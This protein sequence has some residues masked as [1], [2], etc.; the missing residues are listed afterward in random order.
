MG[1]Y[2]VVI[3]ENIDYSIL[4]QDYPFA[5]DRIEGYVELM[6][7][8]C[9]SGKVCFFTEYLSSSSYTILTK[10]PRNFNTFEQD[11]SWKT[12]LRKRIPFR[13]SAEMW[14]LFNSNPVLHWER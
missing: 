2:R 1:A 11:I 12:W 5:Q 14:L 7:E 10:K 3:H 4:L 13:K 9:C 6:A 8:A